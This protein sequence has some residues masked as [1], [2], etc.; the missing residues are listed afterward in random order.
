[1]KYSHLRLLG[2][3]CLAL[4]L[5]FSPSG[6]AQSVV[7]G[8]VDGTVLDSSGA[9]VPNATVNLNNSETGFNE[10]TT[11]GSAGTFRFALV[12]PGNYTLTVVAA[13]FSKQS[14]SVLVSLGQVNTIPVKLEVGAKSE[15][16]EVTSDSPLLHTENANLATTVD[17]KSIDLIPSPGQDITNYV[18]TT[19]GV[20]LST[21]GGYGN[22]TA[23]GL[24]GTSNLYTVNGNDYNDPYL[25]LNNSGAS[26]LL[27]GANELQELTVVTNG[28]TGEYGRAAGANVNYTTKSGTNQFHGNATWFYNDTIMNANDFFANNGGFQAPGAPT[29]RP[30]AVSNQWAGSVGGPIKKDKLFFFYDNEGLRYVLPGGGGQVWTPTTQF[31]QAVTA[32]LTANNPGAVSFYNTIF[33]LYNGASGNSRAVDA[34]G[35]CGALAGTAVFGSPNTYFDSGPVGATVIPCARSFQSTVN[36]LNKERLQSVTIDLNATSKDTLRWRYKQDRGVQATGTDPINSVF[37]ANSVQP[38]DDGQMLWTHV[39]NNHTTNQFV[40]SGLYYSAIFGPPDLAASLKAFPTTIAFADGAPFTNLGGSDNAYPQ[41]RNV[42]QWQLVDDFSW[43]KGNHGIKFGV[44]FRRNDISSFAAGGNT[45]GLLTENSL[46]EFYAGTISTGTYTQTFA[47]ATE[48]P[49]A[50]YSLGLYVQDEWRVTNKLKLTLALRADRNS[51]EVCQ[52]NCFSR[53]AGTFLQMDH[54]INTPYNADIVSGLHNAF[55]GLQNVAWG[56]R[57][58]FAWNPKGDLV[59]RGGF[60]IFSDLYQGLIAD[61]FITNLPNVNTFVVRGNTANPTIAISPGQAG[62]IFTQAAAS[63]TAFVNAYSSGGTLASLQAVDPGFLPPSLNTIVN[64]VTNP[65]YYEWNLQVEKAFGVKTSLSVN[66]VGNHGSNEFIRNLG[67]NTYCSTAVCPNGFDSLPSSAPDPRFGNVTELQNNGISNYNGVT[68]TLTRRFG[69]GF[70]GNFTYTYSHSLDDVSNGGLEP[71]NGLNAANSFR[72][73]IDPNNLRRLNYSNSDYDFPHSLSANYFWELPFKSANG[74]LNQTIGGWTIAGTFFAKSGEPFSVYDTRTRSLLGNG[75]NTL[76]LAVY[77]SGPRTCGENFSV[78]CLSASQFAFPASGSTQLLGNVATFGNVPR[79]FFRGPGFFDT[80]L[81]L[82]KNFKISERYI[83]T[84][85]ANAFNVLNHPNFDNPHGSVTTG[86][87]GQFF[88]SVTPPNSPY[89]NFQ[90]ATVSGRVLQIDVKF[91]F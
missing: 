8:E 84:L 27:L 34:L 79:N 88:E 63:N 66:Y 15:T 50:Y 65:H 29:P 7:S 45:S 83:F 68:A 86:S 59:V 69:H 46:S 4:I 36:N 85:G 80:D 22:F 37:N 9:V 81:S 12:K 54:N 26:N 38:E 87:F 20:T 18:M 31:E 17:A 41:G 75:S 52:K 44:N 67:V 43:T 1:V 14:R 49:V 56:P 23:N 53:P 57:V 24:P 2:F 40:A 51:N 82:Q 60:G 21:G 58:G 32:N 89:G 78:L 19:P 70:Q 13:G 72:L 16:I 64:N 30:H 39:L 91:K 55:P 90:G 77:S 10:T 25:N 48:Q 42:T 35:Q 3:S 74:I 11:T 47:N 5:L 28:Y 62:N 76:P 71:Y 33:N 61:R 73:A 6:K